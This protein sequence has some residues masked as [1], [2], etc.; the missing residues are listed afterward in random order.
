MKTDVYDIARRPSWCDRIL[1]KN[2][3]IDC[4][5]I[6]YDADLNMLNS[7]H[8]PVYALYEIPDLYNDNNLSPYLCHFQDIPWWTSSVYFMCY[9]HFRND[10][11]DKHGSRFDWIGFFKYPI[12]NISLPEYWMYM[13]A[14]YESDI[15]DN[16][17][18]VKKKYVAEASSLTPG[19]YIVAYY[20]VSYNA[21]IGFSNVFTVKTN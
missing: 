15:S 8:L 18:S 9:F 4:K 16:D 6:A 12:K 21:C 10:Y 14:T 3:S 2:C 11:Y 13:A 5:N 7:D 20:S 1:V 17:K 19:D